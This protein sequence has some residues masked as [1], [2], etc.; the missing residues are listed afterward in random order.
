LETQI[1]SLKEYNTFG[2]EV[3]ANNFNI[4]KN[5]DEILDFLRENKNVPLIL[6]GG[7]NILFKKTSIKLF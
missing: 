1:T 2:I 6:G 5:E 3:L 7:S 4:A